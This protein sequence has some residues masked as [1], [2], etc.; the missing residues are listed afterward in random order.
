MIVGNDKGD[1]FRFGSV[2]IK[3]D[4][5]TEILKKTR[6]V[7]VRF[8][9]LG[10]KPVQTGLA[11]FFRFGSVFCQFGSVFFDLGSVQFFQF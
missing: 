4:N 3:K 6:P 2:F 1:H 5:K 9:F 11:R 8:I 7:S 10:P